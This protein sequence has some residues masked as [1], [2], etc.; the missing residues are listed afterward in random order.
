VFF[1]SPANHQTSFH[2]AFMSVITTIAPGDT[3]SEGASVPLC[4]IVGCDTPL[5]EGDILRI[6]GRGFDERLHESPD[7]ITLIQGRTRKQLEA[8]SA[9]LVS[10]RLMI[11]TDT[12]RCPFCESADGKEFWFEDHGHPRIVCPNTSCGVE[13]CGR[14]NLSPYHHHCKC[15]EVIRYTRAWNE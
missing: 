10:K 5:T 3:R 7:F 2:A 12:M 8:V 14:C 4:P 15:D 6:I 9:A 11:T 13:F 1:C